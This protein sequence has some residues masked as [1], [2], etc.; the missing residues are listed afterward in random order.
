MQLL[1]SRFSQFPG[2]TLPALIYLIVAYSFNLKI[3]LLLYY[4]FI[5]VSYS[6]ELIPIN[7]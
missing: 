4:S 6:K 2:K 5:V 3:L 7:F 1:A